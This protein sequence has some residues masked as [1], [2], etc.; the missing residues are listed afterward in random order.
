MTAGGM[1]PGK[2]RPRTGCIGSVRKRGFIS[3]KLVTEGTLEEKIAA[4]IEKKKN[5]MDAVMQED[6]PG[7]LKTFSREDLMEM[8]SIPVSGENE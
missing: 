4:I 6:D 5:I 3:F 2:T 7:L 1:R 8:L